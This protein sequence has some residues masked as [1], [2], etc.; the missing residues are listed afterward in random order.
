MLW[1]GDRAPAVAGVGRQPV[2]LALYPRECQPLDP[3]PL[4]APPEV[5]QAVPVW[6][7]TRH[8]RW[9]RSC[10]GCGRTTAARRWPPRPGWWPRVSTSSPGWRDCARRSAPAHAG[11]AWELARLRARARPVFGEDADLLVLT[12]DT[13]EQAGRPALSRP[14]RGPA[15]GRRRRPVR[16]GRRPGLRRGHRHHRARAG[17]RRGARR[18]PR[19]GGPRAHRRQHRSPRPGLPRAGGRRERRRAGGRGRGRPGRRLP[20]AVLDPARRAAGRRQLDPDRWSPPWPTVAALLDAVPSAVV[21]VAPG[22]DHD[23]VPAGV[24]AEWVS[25]G[26]SVVEALLW[27]RGRPGVAPGVAGAGGAR[28]RRRPARAHRRQRSRARPRPAR[29]GGGCTSPTRR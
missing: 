20:V 5:R 16:A 25:V 9:W 24:E 17:R 11:A 28:G 2:S 19:P 18:R 22:L 4:W 3:V 8:P 27:G 26:G 10:R 29:C 6:H 7:P 13:L 15:A 14:A 23:R 12:A 21:K 1:H